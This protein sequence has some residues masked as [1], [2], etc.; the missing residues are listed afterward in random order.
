MCI[1]IPC[2][3]WGSVVVKHCTTIGRS[4]DR[5][6]VVSLVSPTDPCAMRSIQPLKVSSR[7][8]SW[9]KGGRCVWLTTYHSCSAENPGP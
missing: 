2:I 1:Y 4:W 3:S 9:S 6:L 8:F 7:D 5:F